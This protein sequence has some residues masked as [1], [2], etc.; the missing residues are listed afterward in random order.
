MVII[1]MSQEMMEQND[2][3]KQEE[4]RKTREGEGSQSSCCK[5][6]LNYTAMEEIYFLLTETILLWRVSQRS[7]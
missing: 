2:R 4:R 1:I 7:I 3:E 5:H 6:S